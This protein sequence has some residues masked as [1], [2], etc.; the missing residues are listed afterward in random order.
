MPEA[1][2]EGGF[3]DPSAEE[4]SER[5]YTRGA[6]D[7]VVSLAA[8]GRTIRL[9][10]ADGEYPRPLYYPVERLPDSLGENGSDR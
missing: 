4:T 9:F 2:F 7:L 1:D 3:G 6:T 5:R 8:N 10:T